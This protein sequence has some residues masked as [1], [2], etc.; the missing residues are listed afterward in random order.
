MSNSM[1]QIITGLVFISIAILF[2][3]EDI[4]S[5]TWDSVE[6]TIESFDEHTE[7]KDSQY[8]GVVENKYN[9]ATVSYNVDGERFIVDNVTFKKISISKGD[10]FKIE[11]SP[12]DP[13]IVNYRQMNWILL[14]ICSTL[15]LS[16]FI[17][18]II[19]IVRYWFLK[20]K[21]LNTA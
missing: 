14:F 2:C 4:I 21:S 16:F 5:Y 3:G 8:E 15:G 18:G 13:Y 11:V 1:F 9:L 10:N 7:Y 20:L 19:N 17:V 12:Y 6:A